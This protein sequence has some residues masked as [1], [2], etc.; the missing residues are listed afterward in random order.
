MDSGYQIPRN[1]LIWLLAA[2]F[3]GIAPHLS[4]LPL[5]LIAVCLLSGG[6][7]VMVYRSRWR[8]PNRWVKAV[9]VLSGIAAVLGHYGT[10][11]G[12]EAGT[13]LLILGFCF[14]LLETHSRRDAFV[15]VVLGFFVVATA[16]FF[17]QSMAITA[18]LM[19]VCF[20]VTAALIGL[21]QTPLQTHPGRTA[22]RAL[23]LIAQ[24]LPLMLVLFIFVPRV[25][26]LWSLDLGSSQARTGLSDRITP[27]DIAQLSRSPEL[28]FRV[29]FD[30]PMPPQH[31]LYWRALVMDHYDGATWSRGSVDMDKEPL[32]AVFGGKQLPW[33]SQLRRLSDSY[34]YRIIMEPTDQRWLFALPAATSSNI[35]VGQS[36]DFRLLTAN[37]IRQPFSYN[38]ES[39]LNY[40]LDE[41]LPGWLARQNTQL[42]GSGNPRSRALA[43]QLK[44]QSTDTEDLVRRMMDMFRNQPFS[45]TLRPPRLQGDR[46]DQFMFESRQGFCSHY[47]GAFVFM[48]RAAGVP[49]RVVA[50]Y[51]GGELNPMGDYLLVHQFD[52][53]AWAEVWMPNRGWTRV[54]PT[55]AIAPSR[56]EQGVEEAL[57][58]E[59]SFLEDSLFSPVRYRRIA[60]LSQLRF[61]MDYINFAWH[62]SVLGYNEKF[63]SEFLANFLGPINFRKLGIWMVVGV[64][65]TLLLIALL[66]FWKRMGA[67][68]DPLLALYM[69][70]CTKMAKRDMARRTGES[71]VEYLGRLKQRWPEKTALM[72]ELTKLYLQGRYDRHGKQGASS[73]GQRL[74][75]IKQLIR[76][77]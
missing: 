28:A 42:P 9:L 20:M 33:Q 36:R 45:Y 1:S 24:S 10:L 69:K 73:R 37:P 29:E 60:W 63:Q 48:M 64:M 75:R 53:H 23:K 43:Q 77:I 51:Q 40:K 38:V 16:F 56:V 14:K 74:L 2:M 70:F 62:R 68:R 17:T 31:K 47:A 6:W 67:P 25:S 57:A 72:E 46:I 66:L 58:G 59:Q 54:D 27:G 21:N 35:K 11:L 19:L 30:G 34:R 18:Y 71:E 22:K 4:R 44:N 41:N 12:P 61:A 26:P 39:Y 8:L 76:T 49:A 15:V 7:R 55:A 5:W 50:G 3:A 65:S 32:V 13:A 52:A